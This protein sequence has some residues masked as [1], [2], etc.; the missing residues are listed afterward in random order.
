MRCSPTVLPAEGGSGKNQGMDSDTWMRVQHVF[1]AVLRHDS[2]DRQAAL[3]EICGG[4]R[5]LEAEVR[6]MLT[7]VPDEGEDA[8]FLEP[9]S[10]STK[11]EVSTP[12][13]RVG[14]CTLGHLVGEGGMGSVFEAI[15]EPWNRRVAV[16]LLRTTLA[17]EEAKHRF[18][19]EAR[20]LASLRHAG[21]AQVFETGTHRDPTTGREIPYIVMEFV[22]GA[23]SITD[24]ARRADLDLDARLDV[25][26]QVCAAVNHGHQRGIVHRDLKPANVLID[27]D[28]N[29]KVIDFGIARPT[30]E[31]PITRGFDTVS[32]ALI[33]T[34]HYMSP[35]RIESGD[36]AVDVRSDVYALGVIAYEL[37]CDQRPFDL[38]DLPLPEMLR[39][40]RLDSPTPPSHLNP[41]L[42]GDLETIVLKALVKDPERRYGSVQAL[43]DDVRRFR[44]GLPILARPLTLSYQWSLFVRRHRALVAAFLLV[45]LAVLGA[46]IVSAV[47]AVRAE[48]RAD[49]TERLLDAGQDFSAWVITD[50]QAKV[51]SLPG[52]TTVSDEVTRRIIGYLERLERE[53]EDR[54]SLRR[55]IARA[56]EQVADIQGNEESRGLGRPDDALRHARK[57]EEILESLVA[58]DPDD[59]TLEAELL[60]IR[61]TVAM[62]LAGTDQ[63]EDAQSLCLE[64]AEPLKRLGELPESRDQA[65]ADRIRCLNLLAQFAVWQ[66]RTDEGRAHGRE[67][68]ALAQET[69]DA[70]GGSWSKLRLLNATELN[71]ATVLMD[72]M[73]YEEA[74]EILE[75]LLDRHRESTPEKTKDPVI[76]LDR[77]AILG[78]LAVAIESQG[79]RHRAMRYLR[80][81]I[82]LAETVEAQDP[83]NRNATRARARCLHTLGTAYWHLKDHRSALDAYVK[84]V[85]AQ[86]RVCTAAPAD[87]REARFL[88]AGL[89]AAA[90]SHSGVGDVTQARAA[91]QECRSVLNALLTDQASPPAVLQMEEA[92][93]LVAEAGVALVAGQQKKQSGEDPRAEFERALDALRRSGEIATRMADENPDIHMAVL[94][95]DRTPRKLALIR[96]LLEDAGD[97]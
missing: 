92:Q 53:A 17:S 72:S 51:A 6:A 90:T 84:L 95:R 23:L 42:K 60:H 5:D 62:A 12:P 1:H 74:E 61:V 82:S 46:T 24:H 96:K 35:E 71:Y 20:V 64:L 47:M 2:R 75:P 78:K 9:P 56:Y 34:P 88:L 49:Q 29:V 69:F 37:L 25:F 70:E 19:F 83:D 11:H 93:T 97:R 57:A 22:P 38:Q 58:A 50:L 15:Q 33:G 76:L 89:R 68:L 65:K 94:M 8:D 63:H 36:G 31:S 48:R 26:L 43:A 41:T 52:S 87:R 86:R 27:E 77:V 73:G 66:H 67:A 39:R 80:E 55:T 7:A 59:A 14:T 13:S 54:P 3:R 18:L 91:L 4:D 79:D 28:G 85:A 40:I 32:G 16:K 81:A 30:G 45:A 44:D 21:I 10:A